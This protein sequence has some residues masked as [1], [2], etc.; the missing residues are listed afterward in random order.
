MN[1]PKQQSVKFLPFVANK[2]FF[3]VPK[4]GETLDE[5]ALEARLIQPDETKHK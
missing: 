2:R 3:T 1:D 5:V 4:F